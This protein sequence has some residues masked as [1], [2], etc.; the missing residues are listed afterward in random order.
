MKISTNLSNTEMAAM[1][2]HLVKLSTAH[3]DEIVLEN[4]AEVK[5][6]AHAEKAFDHMIQNLCTE[7]SILLR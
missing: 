5:L 6:L 2:E 1:G 7:L 3:Q 4:N